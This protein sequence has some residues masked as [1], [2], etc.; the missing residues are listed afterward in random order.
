MA[1]VTPT[2]VTV[3]TVLTASRYNA[4][5]TD[6]MTELAPFFSAWTSFTPT[7]TASSGGLN[8]GS[9]ATQTGAYLKVGRVMFWRAEWVANGSGI[10]AGTGEYQFTIPGSFLAAA[11]TAANVGNGTVFGGSGNYSSCAAR[12][13]ST[14]VIRFYGAETPTAYVGSG[15]FGAASGW[16]MRCSGIIETTT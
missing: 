3:G 7:L 13:S 2:N 1:F 10:A 16:F 6:N 8:L 9:T 12:V 5:V 11:P 14:S 4:D 15:S